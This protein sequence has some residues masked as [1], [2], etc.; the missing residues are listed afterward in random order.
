L[1]FDYPYVSLQVHYN[2][3]V[4]SDGADASGVAY[5]TTSTPRKNVAG[6]STLGSALFSIPPSSHEHP[7]TASCTT[8]SK[9]GQTITVLEAF[10][11]MHKLG[12]GFR[13]EHLR[14]A[15]AL[16]D[17][18]NIP[19]GSWSFEGQKHYVTNRRE[20]RPGDNLKTTCWYNNPSSVAVKFGNKT[21]DEMCFNFIVAYPFASLNGL[22]AF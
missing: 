9:D 18:S 7:V 12:T 2:N 8:L 4:H 3:D 1:N 10:P 22:C 15:E 19:M 13:T 11:H 6:I 16:P 14:G 20:I 5:C 21:E 17:L